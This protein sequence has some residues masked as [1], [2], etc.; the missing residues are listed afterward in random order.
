MKSRRSSTEPGKLAALW[1]GA[2]AE[3]GLVSNVRNDRNLESLM[4]LEV[5]RNFNLDTRPVPISTLYRGAYDKNTSLLL[6][7]ALFQWTELILRELVSLG[8]GTR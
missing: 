6:L 7:D 8:H 3:L 2:W 5:M 4:G 1:N